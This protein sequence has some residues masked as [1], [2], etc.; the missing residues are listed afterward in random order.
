[1]NR[2]DVCVC[3]CVSVTAAWLSAGIPFSIMAIYQQLLDVRARVTDSVR[4]FFNFC[5][6]LFVC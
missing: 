5:A 3:V 1:M 4:V 6:E 2:T